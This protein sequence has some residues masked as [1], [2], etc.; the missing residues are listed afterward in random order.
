MKKDQSVN[1]SKA[2]AKTMGCTNQSNWIN[3]L[4]NIEP[5]ILSNYSFNLIYFH[6]TTKFIPVLGEAYYPVEA[7]EA[8]KTGKFNPNIKILAGVTHDEGSFLVYNWLNY[9]KSNSTAQFKQSVIDFF[10][11]KE[12]KNYGKLK[13]DKQRKKVL[14]YYLANETEI[15]RIKNKAGHIF[16]DY[17]IA[18]PTYFMQKD[19]T[20]WSGDNTVYLYELNYRASSSVSCIFSNDSWMG[21]CHGETPKFIF[22]EILRF[23]QK[24][25]QKDYQFSLLIMN[26]WTNFAKTG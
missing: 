8:V 20:L 11:Y 14:D 21:V 26:L 3:C 4:K 5:S 22:G 7:H 1:L 24:Y 23:P 19:I 12:I 18:C 2:Y 17:S 15:D 10:F 16:G 9:L 13:D 25:N 6:N